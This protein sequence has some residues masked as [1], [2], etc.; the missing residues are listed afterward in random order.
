M[1]EDEATLEVIRAAMRHKTPKVPGAYDR[2]HKEECAFSF[3]TPLS[4]GGLFVNLSSWQ[5]YGEE[6]VLLDYQRSNNRL[7]LHQQWHKVFS[8]H[9][10]S[11]KT[12]HIL[13]RRYAEH[14]E[15]MMLCASFVSIVSV[16][17]GLFQQCIWMCRCLCQR[18]RRQA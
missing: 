11:I 13:K 16:Y 9:L 12:M 14:T 8:P 3:D 5:S 6:Y 4:P 1:A 15:V 17:G 2:V 10:N 18:R 7:Y